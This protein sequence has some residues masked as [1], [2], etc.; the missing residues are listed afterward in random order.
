MYLLTSILINNIVPVFILVILGFILGRK[1]PMDLTTLSKL[2]FYLFI[3]AFAFVNIITVE[4]S[5]NPML[6]VIIGILL[7]VINYIIGFGMSKIFRLPDQTAKAFQNTIMFN[8]SGNIGVSIIVLVFSN[9]PFLVNGATVNLEIALAVQIMLLLVQNLGTNTF[10]VINSGGEGMTI[11]LGL[12]RLLQIPILYMVIAAFIIRAL[13]IDVTVTPI[14]SALDLIRAGMVS[15]ALIMLGLQ[16]S[17]AKINLRL[18]TPYVAAFTRL[19]VGPL[20]AFALI[21]LFGVTGIV[22]QAIFISASTPTA[23]NVALISNEFRGDSD[24]TVQVVTLSTL[25]SAFT[26]TGAIYLASVLW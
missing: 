13:S 9:E 7:I 17:Q 5:F 14:W 3:P 16:L 20:I 23:V 10:G 22:A 25:L 1:F 8:N 6:I 2:F 4:F 11:R 19:I 26:M 21:Q 18:K 15:M 24:F 12:K